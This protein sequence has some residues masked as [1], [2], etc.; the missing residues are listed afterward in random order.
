MGKNAEEGLGK[1]VR[2][3]HISML[4]AFS[5]ALG[6]F[7]L[8]TALTIHSRIFPST[9]QLI[10]FAVSH[11]LKLFLHQ[12]YT[13]IF[14]SPSITTFVFILCITLY[15]VQSLEDSTREEEG[16]ALPLFMPNALLY[17]FFG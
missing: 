17:H 9:K 16:V 15:L 12:A 3:R 1:G 14:F 6:V 2:T 10:F 7:V 13:L 11:A 4:H 8:I 5:K